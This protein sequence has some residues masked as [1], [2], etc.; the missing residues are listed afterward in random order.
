MKFLKKSYPMIAALIMIAPFAIG[1]PIILNDTF[2]L[3]GRVSTA[4]DFYSTAASGSP[5]FTATVDGAK[6]Y[7]GPSGYFD[8]GTRKAVFALYSSTNFATNNADIMAVSNS[9]TV[10]V[11]VVNSSNTLV[12]SA[13]STGKIFQVAT[14]STGTPGAATINQAAGRSSIA[15]GAASVVITN[16]LVTAP[17]LVFISPTVRDATCLLPAVTTTTGG[18]F[19]VS[20]TGTNC[21]AALSFN[22]HVIN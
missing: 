5:S 1:A 14:D 12:F 20:T 16:S 11:G 13:S 17:S 2:S 22:W 21:T 4:A 10:S 7:V 8:I 6:L 9:S 15:A 3:G 18:S 19:T